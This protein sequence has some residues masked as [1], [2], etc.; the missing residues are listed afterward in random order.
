MTRRIGLFQALSCA[1][2]FFFTASGAWA[3]VDREFLYDPGR[4]VPKDSTLKVAVGEQAP[5]FTLPALCGHDVSLSDYLG[6]KNV[7]LSFVPAAWTPVCSDQWP[8]YNL[9]RPIFE[10]YDAVVLGITVD[11]IPSLH[12]WTKAMGGVWF[13][14]LSDF[15]PHGGVAEKYGLLRSGGTSERAVIIIDK[16]G[17]IRFIEVSDINRRPDLGVIA[18]ELSKLP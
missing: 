16:A 8:G 14:V 5:D 15:W 2:L 17:T 1:L 12:A 18:Q 7:M 4:Q 10:Q 9:A 13:E 11:N 3:Q 6:K